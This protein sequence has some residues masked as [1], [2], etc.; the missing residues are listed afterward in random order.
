MEYILLETGL[1]GRLDATNVFRKPYLTAITSVGM[2]HMEYLGDTI[3]EI[4]SEKAG[5]IKPK[6][7][8]IYWGED[9]ASAA[10]I[11]KHAKLND[12]L[13]VKV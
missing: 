7:Q 11:E 2:D 3:E 12:S 9:K 10:V 8:V 1:G 4:A 13:A 6:V 5:I